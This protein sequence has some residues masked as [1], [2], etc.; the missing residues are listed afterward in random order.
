MSKFLNFLFFIFLA[1]CSYAQTDSCRGSLYG[2]IIDEHDKSLL[3]FASV[4]IPEINKG[5]VANEDAKYNIEGICDGTYTVIVS[6]LGCE[7]KTQK[8]TVKGNTLKNFFLEHHIEALKEINI[9]AKK[10][11]EKLTQSLSEISEKDFEEAKG[12]QLGDALKNIAGVTTLQTGN[13]ISKPVIHGLHSNRIL[14]LNNGVRQEGQQWGNEHAP[15]IDPFTA[16]K[17]SVIKGASAVRYGSDAMGGTIIVDQKRLRDTAGVGGELN[18]I[19]FSNGRQGAGSGML[20]GNFKKLSPLSWRVQGTLKQGGNINSPGYYL[21]NTGIK[22]YDFSYNLVWKKLNYGTEIYYSQ[23]NTT[24]GIFSGSHI[25]NITDLKKAFESPKPIE[26]SGFSYKIERPYQHIEH[27]LFKSNSFIRTGN[28]GK[29]LFTYARQYNL[30]NEFDKH[31]S[32]SDTLD[33]PALQFEI[34]T[35]TGEVLWEHNTFKSFKGTIGVNG[36]TQDNT[37]EGRYFIPNF[38]NYSSGAFWIERYKLNKLELEA[39]IRYD[40]KYIKVYKYEKK[41]L[42]T[43]VYEFNNPSG[44]FGALYR[45]DSLW[46]LSYNFGTAWRAPGVNE[47]YSD[48][49]HHGTATVEVGNKFLKPETALNNILTAEYNSDKRLSGQVSVYYNYIENFVYQKPVQPPTVTIRGAFP[50]FHYKQTDAIL[51][52]IDAS[53]SFE[54]NENLRITSKA[55]LLRA[56]NKSENNWIVLMPADRYDVELTYKLNERK[57]ISNTYFSL[58]AQYVTKQWRVPDNSDFVPQP[59]VYLLMNFESSCTFHFGKEKITVGVGVRNLLN[60]AYRD[61]LDRFRY[62]TDAIGRNF[63]VRVKIPFNH[64]NRNLNNN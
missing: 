15:E 50:T 49:L 16:G 64:S 35:H 55:S 28:S 52:G 3:R 22:E 18:L 24:L 62:Y 53:L 46:A 10:E 1:C 26:T 40:Y 63:I 23:F 19:G 38:K 59:S 11:K 5:M 51:K 29:L 17:I 44:T 42:T 37:Y 27:E 34:T 25:G 41:I 33:K 54:L 6:H 60:Q 2:Q 58:N 30:R 45:P 31:K 8:V 20:E 47:L 48:G 32:F 14:I 61:Y 43:P 36:I 4:Y 13:N 12:K 21:K 57:K 56:W 9:S 39:G 7:T